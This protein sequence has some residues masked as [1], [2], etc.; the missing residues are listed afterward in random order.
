MRCCLHASGGWGE[1]EGWGEGLKEW[2]GW[3][4]SPGIG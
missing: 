3:G 4:C 1:G 2:D